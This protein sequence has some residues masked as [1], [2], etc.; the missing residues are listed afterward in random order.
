MACFEKNNIAGVQFH[1]ELS[2]TNGLALIK[3]FIEKF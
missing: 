1:P 3:N 2:Q